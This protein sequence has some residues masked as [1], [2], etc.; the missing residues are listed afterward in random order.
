MDFSIR[1]D[2]MDVVK[3]WLSAN[4]ATAHSLGIHEYDGLLPDYSKERI[5]ARINELEEDI[6][7][8]RM[9]PAKT[10]LEQFELDLVR[11]RLEEELFYLSEYRE[12]EENPLVYIFPL[13][14]IET[15]Y[16]ARSFETVDNRIQ[17]IISIEKQIPRYLEIARENLKDSLPTA[18][19]NMGMQFLKGV[20]TFLKDNLI[21]FIVQTE[22]ENLINEWSEANIRAVGALSEFFDALAKDYLPKSHDDFAM[23]AE[24]FSKLLSKTESI[25][26]DLDYLLAVGEE[27]LERNYSAMMEILAEKGNDFIK[28]VQNDHPSAT[29]L[30]PT[31]LKSLERTRDFLIEKDVVTL[32][33]TEQCA[34][35]P[36][37]KFAR[38]FAFAAMS[39]PGPF[40]KDEVSEAYYWVTPPDPSWPEEKRKEFLRFFSHAFLE[41]VTVH[42]V[43]PGHYLQLLYNRKAESDLIKMFA[44]SVTMIEGYAHYAE[45]MVYNEGYEPFDRTKLHVGQLLGALIRNC[46]YIAAI[47][48]HAKGMTV[49]EAKDLFIE[50]GFMTE[51]AAMVEASRGT[52]NP[53]Y[54]NYTLG[55]LLIKKLRK[56]YEKEQ[57]EKFSLKRFH[58]E[59]LSYGSPPI[60][61]LR[62]VMLQ[63][64]GSEE[65]L[66]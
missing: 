12:F 38:G 63:N 64:P 39:T 3:R 41:M 54:L 26:L 23:G 52:V 42:E 40:E 1:S 37:P 17:S 22:N 49:Q 59:L 24:K 58:D 61:L 48:M 55:K 27:D 30:I 8:V 60:T 9:L 65:D 33:T 47:K 28:Q 5:A 56:D 11:L 46:R 15:S 45:E 43:W 51:P 13:T 6:E 25:D 2:L 53:M 44:R 57:G 34:V 31:V 14:M 21:S 29:D 20:M 16:V 36:T 66:L 19:V 18:K 35:V 62:R 32:P 10:K 7:Y 4:P 50:K